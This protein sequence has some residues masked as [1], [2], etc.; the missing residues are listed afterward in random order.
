MGSKTG[1]FRISHCWPYVKPKQKY[2]SYHGVIR[3]QQPKLGTASGLHSHDQSFWRGNYNMYC[4]EM[5][6]TKSGAFQEASCLLKQMLR[7]ERTLRQEDARKDDVMRTQKA[8]LTLIFLCSKEVNNPNFPAS[9][10]S[11]ILTVMF[12]TLSDLLQTLFL[13]LRHKHV[14]QQKRVF[15]PTFSRTWEEPCHYLFLLLP[16]II[17]FS[18]RSSILFCTI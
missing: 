6:R 4:P 11:L 9:Y 13:I 7:W 5:A 17:I 1:S 3:Q 16:L 14:R 15:L 12:I 18:S 8:L 10:Q 2:K